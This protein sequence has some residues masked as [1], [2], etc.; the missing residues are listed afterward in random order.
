MGCPQSSLL[1]PP[2][3]E[4]QMI[5][6]TDQD[7]KEKKDDVITSKFKARSVSLTRS[8]AKKQASP[9]KN[10]P[11]SK[12]TSPGKGRKRK[13][14]PE[15]SPKISVKERT[16]RFE[17]VREKYKNQRCLKENNRPRDAFKKEKKQKNI[18]QE[19]EGSIA[20][21]LKTINA[22]ILSMKSDLKTKV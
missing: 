10:Y 7:L 18:P 11:P 9:K 14:P 4:E 21:L 3:K 12:K 2:S 8:D 6:S 22:N 17:Q 19:E 16:S 5:E 13:S 1:M 15:I 20:N